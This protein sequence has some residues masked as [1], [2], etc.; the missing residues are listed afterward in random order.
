MLSGFL[1]TSADDF[2]PKTLKSGEDR[3]LREEKHPRFTSLALQQQSFIWLRATPRHTK[4]SLGD[5]CPFHQCT[6]APAQLLPQG[7]AK[8]KP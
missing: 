2:R 7:E 5:P 1:K 6:P 3:V 8:S 4:Q